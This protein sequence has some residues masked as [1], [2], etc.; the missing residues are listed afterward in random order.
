MAA[1]SSA[2][3]FDVLEITSAMVSPTEAP[4]GASPLSRKNS[5]SFDRPGR[6]AVGMR[7]NVRHPALALG[8][9]TARK[10]AVSDDAAEDV[11]RAVALGAVARAFHEIGAAVEHC[12]LGGIG[13]EQPCRRDTAASRGRARGGC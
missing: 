6:H 9:H 1:R 13:R 4:S 8:I 12:A 10:A 7:R 3:S 2:V 5:I 11:A